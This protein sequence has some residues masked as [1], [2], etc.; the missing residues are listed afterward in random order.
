MKVHLLDSNEP[1][2]EGDDLTAL[3]C[4]FIPKAAFLFVFDTGLGG[5]AT[6]NSLLTCRQCR[7]AQ[8]GKRYLYGIAAGELVTRRDGAE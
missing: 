6:F 1:M 5:A 4:Q 8:T 3:C 7:E 2:K